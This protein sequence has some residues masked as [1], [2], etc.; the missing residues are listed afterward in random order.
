MFLHAV[1][2]LLSR[3]EWRGSRDFRELAGSGADLK[4]AW[5]AGRARND[6]QI[7]VIDPPIQVVG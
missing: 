7:S 3:A 2:W 1:S 6:S 4:L 5:I